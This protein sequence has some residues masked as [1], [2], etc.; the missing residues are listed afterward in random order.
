MAGR[1]GSSDSPE[2]QQRIIQLMCKRRSITYNAKREILQR[3]ADRRR[4]RCRVRNLVDV[5]KKL[6]IR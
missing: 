2:M 5:P 6:S 1:R 4:S 3:D